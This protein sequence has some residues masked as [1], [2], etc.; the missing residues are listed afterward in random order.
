MR[1]RKKP[2]SSFKLILFR[3]SSILNNF[4]MAVLMIMVLLLVADVV[5]RRI[6]NSPLSWSMEV[7]KVMLV[8][9]VFFAEAYCG[10]R[11]GHISIDILTSR[12]PRK[13]QAVLNPFIC[14]LG[15]L[16]FG[17]MAW[18]SSVSA[19]HYWNAHRIT[20]I[21]P[22]PISPF[23]L[24]VAFGSLVFALVLLVQLVDSIINVEDK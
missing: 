10:T 22:I 13:V 21:L 9:V 2:G 19:I 3:F 6:F 1:L 16:L 23:V 12:F 15:V 18:G 5:L 20:G 11:G 4:G 17:S 8:V 24:V 7:V 14:F